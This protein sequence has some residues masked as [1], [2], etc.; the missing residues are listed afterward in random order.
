[1][2]WISSRLLSVGLF[3]ATGVVL[4][5][6][7]GVAQRLNWIRAE[8]ASGSVTSG[9]ADSGTIYTCP[10]HPNIR[11][12]TTGR[13]PICGME[14]V[15][16]SSSGGASLD[17]YAVHVES[18]QR[19][20]A[21]IET[22]EVKSEP[23]S[24]TLRTIGAIAIDESRQATI[25]AYVGGRL[26][27][28]FADYTGVRIDKGDHLAIIYSPQL[29]G[30]QA[31]YIEARRA[32]EAAVGSIPAVRQAQESLAANTLH[33]LKEFG[34]TDEQLRQLEQGGEPQSRL[35]IYAPQGGTVVEKLAIEGNYVEAGDPIYRIAELSTVWL[36]LKLFPEDADM[37]RF[38]QRVDATV[39]SL[40]GQTLVGRVAFIDPTVDPENRTVDVRVELDNQEGRLRPGDYA[41]ARIQLP[42]G[43]KGEVFDAHLAGK[44]ISPM[45]PQIVRDEPGQCPICGM[46]L[47]PTSEYG[48]A[49]TA[50]P[51]PESIYVPRSAVLL[52]GGSSVVYVET[53]PGRFEIRPIN[54]GPIL[55]DK[56]IILEGLKP[57]E[58]VATSGNFLIDSQM[59]LAGKP[60][61]IDPTRAIAKQ[62]D[63]KGPLEFEEIAIVPVADEN[64][65][66]L[67]QLYAAYFEVQ[68]ALTADQTP[69]AEAARQLAALARDLADARELPEASRK[70]V[71]E[72]STEGE[73]LHHMDLAGARKA[74]KPISHAI[75]TLA[76]QVRSAESQNSFT[77]FFCPM[78]PGGGGDWLQA[79]GELLNPYF[80]SQM[81]R[82][83]EK[84]AEYG[85]GEK[86]PAESQPPQPDAPHPPSEG[87]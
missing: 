49:T 8:P 16:A 15:P 74:F 68:Q 44:W 57:G 46:D 83:G 78:V 39:Q 6:L 84:V 52:A 73:H 30:A 20:L 13:C 64:G 85:G 18:A 75:V 61:L 72:I 70:L 31:E 76:T 23:L 86:K 34:M 38:G 69:P 66:K 59:Q 1:M 27:R 51:Q 2:A 26:E 87:V 58:Q 17:E 63:R 19:R 10:M 24:A 62:Q 14:L 48:Y 9:D 11:Q 37:V 41:E 82:C 7:L 54:I 5:A 40:S 21:N 45:H 55:E 36:M 50:V 65:T 42:I 35:T 79:G 53:E 22:A 32:L 29:F 25:A 71:Q 56:I 80:G 77:H 67:E 81:L 28:L 33:R 3:F 60:S 47:V 4:I 43:P 12:P